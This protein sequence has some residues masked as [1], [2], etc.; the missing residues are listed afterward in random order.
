M[1]RI[2]VIG[3]SEGCGCCSSTYYDEDVE[4]ELLSNLD[5]IKE[6]CNMTD[7]TLMSF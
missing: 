2:A 3:N 1:K 6:Y 5:I 4:I 7:K